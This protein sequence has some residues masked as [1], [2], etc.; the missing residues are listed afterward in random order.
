MAKPSPIEAEQ[1]RLAE[2]NATLAKK[3]ELTEIQHKIE[4][5][6]KRL[7]AE[8]EKLRQAEADREAVK[9]ST[10]LAMAQRSSILTVKEIKRDGR[11]IAYD[12]G[13]VLDTKNNL[14]WAARDNGRDTT[15]NDAKNYCE[16]YRGGGYT[17][18]RMPAQ[19]EL[20]KL[21]DKNV[22]YKPACASSGDT[23]NVH[24]TDFI[25]LSCWS[26][27]AFDRRGTEAAYFQFNSGG[28][29]WKHSYGLNLDRALPVRDFK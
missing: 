27:W 4:E 15:F 6:K 21:Y 3:K 11:F 19:Y 13:T 26:A 5:E 17:D 1:H 22:G 28:R 20:V 7:A 25:T 14:M 2:E 23:D 10:T 9:K 18:W 16:G 8:Q 12:N 29:F 24:L